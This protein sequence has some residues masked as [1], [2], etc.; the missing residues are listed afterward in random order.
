MRLR[1]AA[2]LLRDQ[3]VILL[4]RLAEKIEETAVIPT[5]AHTHIQPAEPTTLGYRFAVYAQDL[6]ED[7]HSLETLIAHLRGKGLKRG[8]RRPS[9][10]PGIIA[11][12]RH[13]A[14][15]VGSQRHGPA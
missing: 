9:Q 13:D 14:A 5:L 12:Q 15:G 1:E 11:G 7:L 3:L 2:V 6:L 4:E 8:G 10:L